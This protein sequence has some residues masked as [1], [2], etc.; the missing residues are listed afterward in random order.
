MVEI[1]WGSFHQNERLS[2]VEKGNYQ[3]SNGENDTA[4][5]VF[6]TMA[7]QLSCYPF[8]NK[9]IASKLACQCKDDMTGKELAGKKLNETGR[10]LKLLQYTY[11]LKYSYFLLKNTVGKGEISSAEYFF[12]FPSCLP[13]FY[14][15]FSTDISFFFVFL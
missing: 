8:R 4:S 11:F 1:K 6:L 2:V 12:L 3:P 7:G 13:S 10:K 5:D 9:V 15:I 14:L